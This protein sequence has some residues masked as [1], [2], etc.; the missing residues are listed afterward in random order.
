MLIFRVNDIFFG[1]CMIDWILGLNVFFRYLF[2]IFEY[3]II[4]FI[5]IFWD[6]FDDF[7]FDSY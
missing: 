2:K 5:D 1:R 7:F 3:I 4:F 6:Y